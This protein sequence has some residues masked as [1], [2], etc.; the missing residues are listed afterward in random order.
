VTTAGSC[1][2]SSTVTRTWTA[3]HHCGNSSSAS[4]TITVQD[5]TAPTITGVGGPMTIECPATPS[6]SSPT[7]TDACDTNPTLTFA[8]VTTA[9]S[10]ER[11]ASEARTW[12]G[13]DHCGNNS[14]ASQTI[15][16]QD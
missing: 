7:A 5:T 16:V 9:R 1:P 2:Q 14:S 3:T 10:E 15:T 11:R 4:H 6:F 13:T 8:D 12:T